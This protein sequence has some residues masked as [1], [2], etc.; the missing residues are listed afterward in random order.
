MYERDRVPLPYRPLRSA[1]VACSSGKSCIRYQL[2]NILGHR[3]YR[4]GYGMKI[5]GQVNTTDHYEQG[6]PSIPERSQFA[7]LEGRTN[8]ATEKLARTEKSSSVIG[9]VCDMN[10][11]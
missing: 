2:L 10:I 3:Q 1:S 5:I 11:D 7:R 4:S 9:R 6:I 8:R